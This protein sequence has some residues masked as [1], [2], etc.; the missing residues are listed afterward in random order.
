[1]TLLSHHIAFVCLMHVTFTCPSPTC[2]PMESDLFVVC[3]CFALP[4]YP[5]FPP[6]RPTICLFISALQGRHL[7][8]MLLLVHQRE[9]EPGRLWLSCMLPLLFCEVFISSWGFV[10]Y[11][12]ANRFHEKALD[13]I[14]VFI[15]FNTHKEVIRLNLKRIRIYDSN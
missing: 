15:M 11:F 9:W 12:V 13:F 2:L 3:S 4:W 5:L 7:Y 14:R 8:M 10:A 6:W 1:M